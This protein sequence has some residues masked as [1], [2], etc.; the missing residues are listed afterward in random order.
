MS[1]TVGWLVNIQNRSPNPSQVVNKP[2]T[3]LGGVKLGGGDASSEAFS[4]RTGGFKKEESI[5]KERHAWVHHYMN[6]PKPVLPSAAKTTGCT[7]LK[8]CSSIAWHWGVTREHFHG[9]AITVTS[10]N[11]MQSTGFTQVLRKD[12]QAVMIMVFCLKWILP[13]EGKY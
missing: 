12:L 8:I 13:E 1:L 11:E 2:Q 9:P 10:I 4:A 6:K 5:W 3:F 7:C